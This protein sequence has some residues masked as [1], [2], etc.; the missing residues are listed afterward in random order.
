MKNKSW[1]ISAT[2]VAAVVV[3][4]AI[5][6]EAH[7]NREPK[8]DVWDMTRDADFVFKGKVIQVQ[9]RNTMV[10]P[11]LDPSSG[12]P[13]FDEEGIQVFKSTS[14]VPHT[15]VTY[16]VLDIYRG[17][18]PAGGPNTLTLRFFGGLSSDPTQPDT[19]CFIS[20]YPHFD[21]G[22]E[23]VLFVHGNVEHAVR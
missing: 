17:Q 10:E 22:H 3:S 12:G 5:P 19:V 15:F 20:P 21:V 18:L 2:I 23:D 11:L 14:N 9:Y 8:L 13:V 1:I 16:D 4:V 6:V 7:F